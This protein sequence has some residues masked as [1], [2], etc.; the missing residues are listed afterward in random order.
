[1]RALVFLC[2]ALAATV[3][4]AAF[5][6]VPKLVPA[7][8]QVRVEP[9]KPTPALRV[10]VA[11]KDLPSGTIIK[12]EHVRWQAWPEQGLSDGFISPL[13]LVEIGLLSAAEAQQHHAMETATTPTAS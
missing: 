6:I 8:Q 7:P 12:P 3:A 1:M 10:L 4:G 5:I 2:L 13:D 11:A 9:P